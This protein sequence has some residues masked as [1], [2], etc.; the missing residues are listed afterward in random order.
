LGI[1]QKPWHKSWECKSVRRGQKSIFSSHCSEIAELER[2]N[3]CSLLGDQ[4]KPFRQDLAGLGMT[5]FQK[6]H[7]FQNLPEF[8]PTPM[9]NSNAAS[10]LTSSGANS[11]L[12]PCGYN[13]GLPCSASGWNFKQISVENMG[14]K[15]SFLA[16]VTVPTLFT[17]HRCESLLSC[18]SLR[19]K[20]PKQQLRWGRAVQVA[21]FRKKSLG[22]EIPPLTDKSSYFMNINWEFPWCQW[23]NCHWY[24]TMKNLDRLMGGLPPAGGPSSLLN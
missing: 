13:G 8:W 18:P 19:A 12:W 22:M 20:D 7:P 6:I 21:S 15:W 24:W 17:L 16:D 10:I 23:K 3:G 14:Q 11:N 2:Q 1:P 4:Q 9:G 5:S